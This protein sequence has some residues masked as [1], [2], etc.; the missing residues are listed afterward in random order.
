MKA[1]MYEKSKSTGSLVVREV[2]K[3]IPA[4]GEVLIKVHAV[5]LNAA[6]YRSMRMGIIPER[7]IFGADVAGSVEAVGN[8]VTRFRV[9]DAVFGDLASC[10][11]G[12]LAEYALAPENLLALKPASVP[13]VKAAALPIAALTALQALRDKGHVQRGQ[14][15]LIVGAGG[16]VGTFAVQ[17]AKHYGAHVTAVCGPRNAEKVRSLGADHVIDYTETDFTQ[18]PR[19]YDLILAVNGNHSLLDYRRL[20]AKK[21]VCVMVGGALQQVIKTMVFGPILSIGGKRMQNLSAKASAT[22]LEFI[23]SL[24]AQGKV[25]PVIDRT[26]PLEQAPEAMSYLTR[27]HALGKVVITV[28]E[29]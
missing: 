18:T 2:E 17:L 14:S 11:F 8:Q 10:G 4:A 25:E 27:G 19:R 21:G 28:V 20:L 29:G 13:W 23:I 1:V 7:K 6:D 9:G 24:V 5:A 15:V 26:Y 12:G 16:G 22:D 3:P